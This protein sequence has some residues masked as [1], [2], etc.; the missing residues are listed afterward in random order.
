[1]LFVYFMRLSFMCDRAAQQL[2][3]L[4]LASLV[5]SGCFFSGEDQIEGETMGTF[6]TITTYRKGYFQSSL[7]T[8]REKIEELLNEIV[9][10]QSTWDENSLISRFNDN[11]ASLR[12]FTVDEHF[13]TIAQTAQEIFLASGGAFNPAM[14]PLI[15]AWGFDTIPFQGL[16]QKKYI[17]KLLE[18]TDF[19]HIQIDAE[20]RTIRRLKQGVTINFS[21]LAK[22][23]AVDQVANLLSH[24][25]YE[26]YLI[27][28]G[29]E[30][31]AH[32]TNGPDEP[33]R[34][35]IEAPRY[36]STVVQD[37][38]AI[39]IV[40]DNGVITLRNHGMATS[41][42]YRNY[43]RVRDRIYSHVIDPRTGEPINNR[44]ASVSVVAESTMVA[45]AW[46]TA[47]MVMGEEGITLCNQLSLA[48]MIVVHDDEENDNDSDNDNNSTLNF[49][50][51]ISRYWMKHKIVTQP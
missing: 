33:W 42:D 35:G 32:G 50:T 29:G 14:E 8:Q 34:V 11:S 51:Y 17:N 19:R 3:I 21:A 49:N 25:G 37:P 30:I 2:A 27:N 39:D 12:I 47:L 36:K 16:P 38:L 1:M 45:D 40:L 44:V 22:G 7:E 28:I 5:L 23:Y 4:V 48:C 15:K 13:A 24:L 26:D 41:G 9:A 46:A 6:Y 20:Q 10:S 18:F 31:Y 43:V